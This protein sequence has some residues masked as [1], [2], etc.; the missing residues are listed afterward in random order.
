M[1]KF[2]ESENKELKKVAED[3]INKWKLIIHKPEVPKKEVEADKPKINIEDYLINDEDKS[4]KKR[5]NTLISI[6]F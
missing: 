4:S 5:N 3:L 2:R 6:E 1:K